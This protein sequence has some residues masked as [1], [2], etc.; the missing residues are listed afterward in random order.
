MRQKYTGSLT[1]I[2][3][4]N[5]MAMQVYSVVSAVFFALLSVLVGLGMSGR[6]FADNECVEQ[7]DRE[8]AQGTHWYYRHDR[9]KNR[10]CWHLEAVAPVTREVVPPQ[11]DRMQTVATP[12]IGSVFSSLFRGLRNLL[13]RSMP[14]EVVAGEPRIIQSDATKPLTIEDI[15]QQQ[16]DLPEERAERRYVTPLRPAQRRALFEDYLKWEE[17]QR[18]LGK[19]GAAARSP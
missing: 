18:G 14:H 16:P 10:R 8:P 1:S 11:T 3:T 19:T 6:A 2:A 7:P 13:R 9:E 15:A 4:E 12:A 5:T 17:L